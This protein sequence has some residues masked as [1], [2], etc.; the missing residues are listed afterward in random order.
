MS[1]VGRRVLAWAVFAAAV[2][3]ASSL[4]GYLVRAVFPTRSVRYSYSHDHP[5][6]ELAHRTPPAVTPAR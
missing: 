5:P 6:A 3:A 1:A 2:L 4:C